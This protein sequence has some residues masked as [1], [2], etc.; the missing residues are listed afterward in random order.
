MSRLL[1][2]LEVPYSSD[3]SKTDDDGEQILTDTSTLMDACEDSTQLVDS[4]HVDSVSTWNVLNE[5]AGR[6]PSGGCDPLQQQ[7]H[8]REG[9][10]LSEWSKWYLRK[11]Q[12]RRM[13]T[14]Q[15]RDEKVCSISLLSRLCGLLINLFMA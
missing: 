2:S 7:Q 5:Y 9:Q 6:E 14:Q 15:M 12:E 1:S 8:Q 10:T 4:C 11:E 13:R 3:R